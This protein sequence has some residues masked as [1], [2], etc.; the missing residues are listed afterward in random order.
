MGEVMAMVCP[1]CGRK[2]DEGMQHCPGCGAK[3]PEQPMLAPAP[4]DAEPA[5]RRT[6]TPYWLALVGGVLLSVG[7][8]LPWMTA[9]ML[10]VDGIQKTGQEAWIIVG[11][12]VIVASVGLSA[13]TSSRRTGTATVVLLFLG[14]A[15]GLGLTGWY[16]WQLWS[17]T[18]GRGAFQPQLGVGL[19]VT[20]AG[21]IVALIGA[22]MSE[23]K[24]K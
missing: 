12:G 1:A 7:P 11:M 6:V 9:G 16:F 4:P 20:A 13:L 10:S 3:L 23:Q 18:Q 22:F 19:Y 2:V 5:Q 15:I 14:S 17:Q 8:F 21:G 24:K